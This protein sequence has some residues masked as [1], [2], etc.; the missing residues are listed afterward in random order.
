MS[1]NIYDISALIDSDI[2]AIVSTIPDEEWFSRVPG[3]IDPPVTYYLT[4]G[5]PEGNFSHHEQNVDTINTFG[6]KTNGTLVLTED[7]AEWVSYDSDTKMLSVNA[8]NIDLENNDSPLPVERLATIKF[9]LEEDESKT[10]EIAIGQMYQCRILPYGDKT[11]DELQGYSSNPVVSNNSE[12][13]IQTNGTL[14]VD[15]RYDSENVD[16]IS[17]S[18]GVSVGGGTYN[19][20]IYVKTNELDTTKEI[21][22]EQRTGTVHLTTEE[23]S[24]PLSKLA[25]DGVTPIESD[26]ISLTVTQ[27]P[28]YY[29]LTTLNNRD[30]T[31][32]THTLNLN[33]DASSNIDTCLSTNCDNI[34][35]SIDSDA[36]EW[37]SVRGNKITVTEN[38]GISERTGKIGFLCKGAG[39]HNKLFFNIVQSVS[40]SLSLDHVD[41]YE[42][43]YTA[44]TLIISDFITNGTV[45]VKTKSD[46]DKMF[47]SGGVTTA[48]NKATLTFSKN[49]NTSRKLST[50][51]TATVTF[52]LAEDHSKTV[53]ITIYQTPELGY[54]INKTT[55]ERN[56]KCGGSSVVCVSTNGT[57]AL[58]DSRQ[59]VDWAT[60]YG[61]PTDNDGIKFYQP[62][63]SPQFNTVTMGS[64]ELPAK[65]SGDVCLK[66]TS[67][68]G[69]TVQ[70]SPIKVTQ[71]A[72]PFVVTKL[73]N[74]AANES[75]SYTLTLENGDEIIGF[76]PSIFTEDNEYNNLIVSSDADWLT[77][78][79]MIDQH[80]KY[81]AYALKFDVSKNETGAERTGVITFTNS[82]ATEEYNLTNAKYGNLNSLTFTVVQPAAIFLRLDTSIKNLAYDA[83]YFS[84]GLD[85]DYFTNATVVIKEIEGNSDLNG[86]KWVKTY[87]VYSDRIDFDLLKNNYERYIDYNL[88]ERTAKVHLST[89]EDPTI[90]V[91]LTIN[92]AAEYVFECGHSDDAYE[93]NYIDN[94]GNAKKSEGRLVTAISVGK[95]GSDIDAKILTNIYTVS[96]LTAKSVDVSSYFIE[97][98]N[99]PSEVP[100]DW[101]AINP[102]KDDTT[103]NAKNFTFTV[104]ANDTT[105]ERYALIE[106]RVADDTVVFT[107]TRQ[108]YRF[109]IIQESAFYLTL[110]DKDN[111]IFDKL[112]YYLGKENVTLEKGTNYNTNATV[113]LN[114]I[115]GNSDLNGKEWVTCSIDNEKGKISISTTKN[116]YVVY[117]SPDISERTAKIHLTTE[118]TPSIDVVITVVQDPEYVFMSDIEKV[119]YTYK[120]IDGTVVGTQ[121]VRLINVPAEGSDS[122]DAQVKTNIL[123]QGALYYGAINPINEYFKDSSASGGW[124]YGNCP[125]WLDIIPVNDDTT[126]SPK[127]FT[128]TVE[129]NDSDSERYALICVA[130]FD[131]DYTSGLEETRIVFLI[132][133]SPNYTLGLNNTEY[134]IESSATSTEI[135]GF[136]TN[137]TVQLSSKDESASWCKSV[138][139]TNN[140]ATVETETNVY[141]ENS[142]LSDLP[143]Q[144]SCEIVFTLEEDPTKT[145]TVKITQNA[146][147][148][149]VFAYNTGQLIK[150]NYIASVYGEDPAPYLNIYTN[151]KDGLAPDINNSDL[152]WI[153]LKT[154]VETLEN[155][156]KKYSFKV[157]ANT[158]DVDENDP[159]NVIVGE[160]RIGK[161]TVKTLT[162]QASATLSVKQ[163]SQKYVLTTLNNP[164]L[165]KSCTV[166]LDTYEAVEFDPKL[167]SNYIVTNVGGASASCVTTTFTSQLPDWISLQGN[168]YM[169]N[170][171]SMKS[172]TVRL[173]IE[174]NNSSEERS[175]T[176]TINLM[177]NGT[178]N[179]LTFT[180][181]QPG[182]N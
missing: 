7:S 98:N 82:L 25:A 134:T 125:S 56:Y 79:G 170:N 87:T 44:G 35:I 55:D 172:D 102:V 161:L 129:P 181:I 72:E 41:Y 46:P 155:G 60:L 37:L 101:V 1:K 128:F 20:T 169:Y 173:E 12:V 43:D 126:G 69:S 97:L 142:S 122:I 131:K 10:G 148:S 124:E 17:L 33:G 163:E 80:D 68:D 168:G 64:N 116:T 111:Y 85:D 166:E 26:G 93:Y 27:L 147:E 139:V 90:D 174:E 9:A 152:T 159:T 171:Y 8:N 13:V 176:F 54:L 121:E 32:N 34:S 136:D 112:G 67:I 127:N 120:E 89:E 75:K 28:N 119:N 143:V 24:D 29:V 16:W 117:N 21:M 167:I 38:T 5:T 156:I 145:V 42:K 95:D 22:S 107:G 31:T 83:E 52:A 36:E 158:I 11:I 4:V 177:S 140:V 88:S 132:V 114:R 77:I 141:V 59:S 62:V 108:V 51:K 47:A 15:N 45:I 58:D 137:G 84:L 70:I 76:D 81:R 73:N 182:S 53:T 164:I 18:D 91:V 99:E 175:A 2:Y 157:D 146:G 160:E 165:N 149:V 96:D 109:L 154:N 144:R 135:S 3:T 138:T 19:Y 30:L 23:D 86:D 106:V 49:G 40:F 78:K 39:E 118:E 104:N 61:Y 103:G 162:G 130:V 48:N 150:G 57:L 14:V 153:H 151:A 178:Y 94:D 6:I 50:E 115:E 65:R 133:Q 123:A 110:N 63:I 180:I 66:A 100:V 74:P 113:A 105:N 179:N 71:T 92:Q